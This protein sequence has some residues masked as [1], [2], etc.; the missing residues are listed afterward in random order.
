V[1]RV[2]QGDADR[3]I[4]LVA[5]RGSTKRSGK[6]GANSFTFTGKIAGHTLTPG[7]FMS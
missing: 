1:Q 6:A 4:T 2:Q 3:C 5:V 7:Q